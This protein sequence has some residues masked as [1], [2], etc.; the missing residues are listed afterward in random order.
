MHIAHK[1]TPTQRA[2]D[3]VGGSSGDNGSGAAAPTS[4]SSPPTST[5]TASTTTT[6]RLTSTHQHITTHPHHTDTP[7]AASPAHMFALLDQLDQPAQ[8]GRSDRLARP[9]QL[10][11]LSQHRSMAC[12]LQ[13]HAA[14]LPRYVHVLTLLGGR[15]PLPRAITWDQSPYSSGL[16]KPRSE[17]RPLPQ[18][19]P[20]AIIT[21]ITQ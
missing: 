14:C 8:L 3:V 9:A 10:V 11:L 13:R 5:A 6:A 18:G 21:I 15:A 16:Y 2:G 1:L 20:T 19:M 7:R 4:P 17:P 12:Q